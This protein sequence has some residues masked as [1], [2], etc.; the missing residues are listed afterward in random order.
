MGLR[1]GWVGGGKMV[2]E[3]WR[4]N[5]EEEKL[6]RESGAAWWGNF[7]FGREGIWEG[8]ERMV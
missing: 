6:T 8:F 1:V 2:R 4:R 5:E 3:D 7:W